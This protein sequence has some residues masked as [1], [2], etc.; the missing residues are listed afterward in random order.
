[1]KFKSALKRSYSL[2]GSSIDATLSTLRTFTNTLISGLTSASSS[3]SKTVE[4]SLGFPLAHFR[5]RLQLRRKESFARWLRRRASNCSKGSAQWPM[6]PFSWFSVTLSCVWSRAKTS[7]SL[8]SASRTVSMIRVAKSTRFWTER[9]QQESR[10]TKI[11][12]FSRSCLS[13]DSQIYLI[14]LY[15]NTLMSS[16]YAWYVLKLCY[17]SGFTNGCSR[18]F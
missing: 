11:F 4:S 15:H 5:P 8:T 1:M 13:D 14:E 6:T 7:F 10:Y 3:N 18:S 2:L 17:N 9:G 16:Y 12:K